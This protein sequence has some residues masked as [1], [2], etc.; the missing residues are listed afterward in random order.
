MTTDVFHYVS[1]LRVFVDELLQRPWSVGKGQGEFVRNILD[2]LQS[3]PSGNEFAAPETKG[4]VGIDLSDCTSENLSDFFYWDIC[5]WHGRSERYL[6]G[7]CSK[8]VF[9][10]NIFFSLVKTKSNVGRNHTLDVR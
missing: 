10:Q 7:H 1:T 4:I 9:E 2:C 5:L 8:F 6:K 3:E